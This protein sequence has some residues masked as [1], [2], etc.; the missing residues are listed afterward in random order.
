MAHTSNFVDPLLIYLVPRCDSHVPWKD[1][2]HHKTIHLAVSHWVCGSVFMQTSLANFSCWSFSLSVITL[3]G[4]ALCRHPLAPQLLHYHRQS[5]VEA[6]CQ[7]HCRIINQIIKNMVWKKQYWSSLFR[8]RSLPRIIMPFK[9]VFFST[10]NDE[11]LVLHKMF[12]WILEYFY[13]S[14]TC[15]TC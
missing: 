15:S 7:L 11:S 2:S 6:G 14:C 3:H 1:G 12:S 5:L 9:I 10:M 8:T 13:H 4:L